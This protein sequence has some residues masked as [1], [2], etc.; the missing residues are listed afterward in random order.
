MGKYISKKGTEQHKTNPI[1]FFWRGRL[2]PTDATLYLTY[3]RVYAVCVL[4]VVA[5][6]AVR[7]RSTYIYTRIGYICCYCVYTQAFYPVIV[8][9][10]DS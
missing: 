3:I 1:H 6:I 9:H 5:V 8:R 7:S 4:R 2:R 10:P